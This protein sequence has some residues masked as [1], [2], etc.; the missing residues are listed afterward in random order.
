[1]DWL[2]PIV[3]ED[4][5][6]RQWLRDRKLSINASDVPSIVGASPYRSILDIYIDK[7]TPQ[8]DITTNFVQQKGLDLEPTARSKFEKISGKCYPPESFAHKENQNY[9]CSM[10]GFN[11]DTNTAIEIKYVGRNLKEVCPDKY[12]PQ[13]QFQYAVSGADLISLVQINDEEEISVIEIKKDD[14]YILKMLQQVQW[15]WKCVQRKDIEEIK[16][17]LPKK[18]ERKKKND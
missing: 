13:I 9:K 11:R 4:A 6:K 3:N 1:M 14:Y 16:K 10:D 7:T 5:V 8:V 2:S 12:Y 15:F 17:A 18:K